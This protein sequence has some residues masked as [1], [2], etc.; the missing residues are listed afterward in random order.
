LYHRD[1]LHTYRDTALTYTSTAALPSYSGREP[2]VHP[3]K[4][5]VTPVVGVMA[6]IL[7]RPSQKSDLYDGSRTQAL[8]GSHRCSRRRTN[9]VIIGRRLSSVAHAR[10]AHADQIHSKLPV[11]VTANLSAAK[12]HGPKSLPLASPGMLPCL[13]MILLYVGNIVNTVH[14]SCALVEILRFRY[15]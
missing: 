13:M 5:T 4:G 11:F 2:S 9:A 3:A 6:D 10:V 14:Y 8:Y 7:I 12:R 1:A 15:R